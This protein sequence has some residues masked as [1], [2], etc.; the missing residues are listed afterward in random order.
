MKDND[1]LYWI[2]LA[3]KCGVA[4]REFSRLIAMFENPFE[5][6]RLDAEEI[7]SI[8]GISE[9]L[10]NAL[11]SKSLEYAY[12]TLKYCKKNGV[13]IIAY[14]DAKYPQRLKSLED[15]PVLLYCVGEL[16]DL[17]RIVSIGVVGTRKMS[18]Y[19]AH[20]AYKISYELASANFTVVSGMA[21]GIDAVSA[22]AA[23]TA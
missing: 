20:S 13:K 4:C 12:S 17:D 9:R 23:L 1:N 16:P 14:S 15:P 2:W 11:C 21:L 3:D 5:I 7:G 22:C 6:Y 19:G 18:A 8:D 10:K